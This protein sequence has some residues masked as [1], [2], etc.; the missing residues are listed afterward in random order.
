MTGK[1][2]PSLAA[3]LLQVW[4]PV[5]L[6]AF[7]TLAFFLVLSVRRLRNLARWKL[8]GFYEA[9]L[10]QLASTL[11][12][13]LKNGADLGSAIEVAQKN[14]ASA[15]AKAELGSWRQRL[16]GGA[17]RFADIAPPGKLTSPL[18]VWLVTSAGENWAEGFR[19]AAEVYDGRAKYR[20]DLVLYAALPVAIL[21]VA[22]I[23][24]S[25]MVPLVKGFTQLLHMFNDIGG[26]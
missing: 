8:P 18:F 25:E 13:M 3:L 20:I 15:G 19:R 10:S 9:S 22:G 17:R 5:A 24:F 21:L 7:T 16:A 4:F 26:E 14:E 23:V 12:M 2:Q 6:L 1:Q 11:A